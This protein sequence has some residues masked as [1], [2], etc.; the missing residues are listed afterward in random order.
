MKLYDKGVYLVNGT[1]IVEDTKDAV[2]ALQSKCGKAP[3]KEEAARGTMA[4]GI[5]VRRIIHPQYG[6]SPDKV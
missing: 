4:Y 5:L 1:E 3:S 2:Q 6:K